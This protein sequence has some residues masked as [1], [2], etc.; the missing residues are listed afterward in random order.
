[1]KKNTVKLNWFRL[2]FILI[3]II[4]AVLM[5]HMMVSASYYGTRLVKLYKN[6]DRALAYKPQCSD[7][8]SNSCV[9][10]K[11]VQTL[12]IM[13]NGYFHGDKIDYII[14]PTKI[15]AFWGWKGERCNR[16]GFFVA[17]LSH[18]PLLYG[19]PS[20]ECDLDVSY[21]ITEQDKINQKHIDYLQSKAYLCQDGSV[22]KNKTIFIFNKFGKGSVFQCPI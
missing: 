7:P 16:I 20:K 18:I 1:M 9:R 21:G 4:S 6:Y 13:K 19:Y 11:I 12:N 10:S 14:M 17:A 3:I 22:Y 5:V 15:H 8:L 2:Q